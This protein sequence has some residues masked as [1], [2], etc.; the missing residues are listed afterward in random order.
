[1]SNQAS[2]STVVL[3]GTVDKIFQKLRETHNLRQRVPQEDLGKMIAENAVSETVTVAEA[4]TGTGKSFAYLAGAL[5]AIRHGGGAVK[6][7]LVATASKALQQQLQSEDIPRLVSAGLLTDN[8]FHVIMGQQNYLCLD[9]ALEVRDAYQEWLSDPEVFVTTDNDFMMGAEALPAMLEAHD[10]G[11]WNGIFPDYSGEL[12]KSVAPIAA[13][14]SSCTGNKCSHYKR[15]SFI[16]AKLR[17]QTV[18]VLVCNHDWLLSELKKDDNSIV[19]TASLVILDEAHTFSEK[20]VSAGTETL[21]VP[22]VESLA[23][24]LPGLIRTSATGINAEISGLSHAIPTAADLLEALKPL[25]AYGQSLGFEENEPEGATKRFPR[26]L[27]PVPLTQALQPLLAL[28]NSMSGTLA[29]MSKALRGVDL[30]SATPAQKEAVRKL[31]VR[32]IPAERSTAS[33]N[34]AAATLF[35][36]LPDYAM[37]AEKVKDGVAFI[38]APLYPRVVLRRYLYPKTARI[39]MVS[40]TLRAGPDFK[41]TLETLGTP[42]NTQ[43]KLLPYVLPYENSELRVP[44][45]QFTP[46]AAERKDY[47]LE[48][49][50]KLPASIDPKEGTLIVLTSW[51]VLKELRPALESRLG[52]DALCVQGDIPLK[53]LIAKHKA[54]IDSGRGS[55]L[56][57]VASLAEGIDLPG[58]YCTHLILNA[59]PFAVPTSPIEQ[60]LSER[61]GS[62]YFG[63]RSLPEATRRLMQIAGRLVR[64]ESDRGRIS[65]FDV[66]LKNTNYGKKMQEALPPF[67]RAA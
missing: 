35:A 8:Q 3:H 22:K 39:C 18:P 63:K 54:R 15:C 37:W 16:Q 53:A 51:Q 10:K 55:V 27:P 28:L 47:L 58:A 38:T 32:L 40:A 6:Q 23:G 24:A 30:S 14:S 7:I 67:K 31:R 44:D 57:G 56:V 49:K 45:M 29:N 21:S 13:D 50:S 11:T 65:V 26:G 60:E 19:G 41:E 36:A 64:R 62:E 9:R 4:P 66:R 33:L 1:M 48:L 2:S 43:T 34:R 42:A 52:S 17:V 59:L 12:P 25:R 20:A 5:A 61:L 46:K